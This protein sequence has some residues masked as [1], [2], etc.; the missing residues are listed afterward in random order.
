[1]KKDALRD[2]LFNAGYEPSA[3]TFFIWGG[4][5]MY[6]TEHAVRDTLRA[7]SGYSATGSSLVMD[8]AGRAMIDMLQKFPQLSQHNY[9]TH[10]GE[11]WT[12]GL[13][14][15]REREFF[16]ECNLELKEIFTFIGRES[17]Q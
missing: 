16:S 17:A 14:D 12:F 11:P 4:V 2:V 15:M 10:W 6:L 9:T 3:K 13:P 8:F 1:F 5:S 7:I